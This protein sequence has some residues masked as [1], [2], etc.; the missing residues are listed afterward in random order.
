MK[1][2]LLLT[3]EECNLIDAINCDN[4]SGRH[5]LGKRS[6]DYWDMRVT[7]EKARLRRNLGQATEKELQTLEYMKQASDYS[8]WEKLPEEEKLFTEK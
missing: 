5:L 2:N 1:E 7:I 4:E 6:E 8:Y 3:E